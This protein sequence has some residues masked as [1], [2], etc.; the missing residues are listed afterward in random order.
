LKIGLAPAF[1]HS[2]DDDD[3]SDEEDQPFPNVALS[4]VNIFHNHATIK[5]EGCH[6]VLHSAGDAAHNTYIR[7]VKCSLL[8]KQ[9]RRSSR[10]GDKT[11]QVQSQVLGDSPGV[12][13]KHGDTIAFGHCLFFF[14]DPFVGSAEMLILSNQVSYDAS[15]RDLSKQRWGMTRKKMM[16]ISAIKG[17]VAQ[18]S[19]KDG[20]A[21]PSSMDG[22]DTTSETDAEDLLRAKDEELR[23]KDEE[24]QR[25]KHE[26]TIARRTLATQCS[27]K[28][29]PLTPFNS[30]VAVAGGEGKTEVDLC[31]EVASVF[32][33]L[34]QR[35]EKAEQELFVH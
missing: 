34:I 7:G 6:C 19:L 13:L 12:V 25:L 35:M 32:G 15:C 5:N 26:L 21:P 3:S 4:G 20:V 30:G 17:C 10:E 18:P 22:V 33:R 14:V 16:A 2:S 9:Q 31:G 27:E 29:P 1:E 28:V 24:I 23:L 11:G 8:L